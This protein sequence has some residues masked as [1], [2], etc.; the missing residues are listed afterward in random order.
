MKTVLLLS[1]LI[2]LA[3]G[4]YYAGRLHSPAPADAG[5][6][7]PAAVYQ[8][9]MHPWI[10]SD[11][12]DA[13][14]T[15]CGMAL[16]AATGAGNGSAAAVDPNLV[17]LTTAQAAVTGVRTD[18]VRRAPL[19]RGLRVNGVIDDDDTRHRILAA[20]VPG[21][22]EKLRRLLQSTRNDRA[23]RRSGPF[24]HRRRVRRV[25]P[26]VRSSHSLVPATVSP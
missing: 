17:T 16:V 21:R 13:K 3:A 7:T 15:I 11:Q 4:G 6:A 26:T 18:A 25:V 8:C 20:R 24:T 14:C 22:I 12:S 9:P 10:K 2:L 5:R 23:R 1:L 19:Q